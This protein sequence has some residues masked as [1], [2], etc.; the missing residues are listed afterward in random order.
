M[1][2]CILLAHV[3]YLVLMMLL[4]VIGGWLA[5]GGSHIPVFYQ[6]GQS[7]SLLQNPNVTGLFDQSSTF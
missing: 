3:G 6:I 4:Q 2:S 5:S 1:E 7:Y